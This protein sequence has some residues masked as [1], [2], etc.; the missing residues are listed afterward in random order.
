MPAVLATVLVTVGQALLV[1][2]MEVVG[3]GRGREM[4][5][6]ALAVVLVAVVRGGKVGRMEEGWERWWRGFLAREVGRAL[7]WD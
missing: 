7:G 1:L 3:G 2:G 4:D 5:R 6:V